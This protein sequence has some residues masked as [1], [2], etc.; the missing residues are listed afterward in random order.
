MNEAFNNSTGTQRAD[1]GNYKKFVMNLTN[2][3][4]PNLIAFDLVM[5]KPMTSRAGFVTY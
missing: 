4:M 5:V 1:I 3:V 2:I